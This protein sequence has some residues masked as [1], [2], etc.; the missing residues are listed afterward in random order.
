M[1]RLRWLTALEHLRERANKAILTKLNS[2]HLNDAASEA[3]A[4]AL[5]FKAN[6]PLYLSPKIDD[7]DDRRYTVSDTQD[8]NKL[9]Y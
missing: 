4:K 5:K 3:T 9:Y 7:F 2:D 6:S 1:N 8:F